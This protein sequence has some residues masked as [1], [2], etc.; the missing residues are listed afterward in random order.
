MR[1]NRIFGAF[2]FVC[3]FAS[4][5]FSQLAEFKYKNLLDN[6]SETGWYSIELGD[7]IIDKYHNLERDIRIFETGRDTIEIP[8][9]LRIISDEVREENVKID[10]VNRSVKDG[11][12]YF[13]IIPQGILN[14]LNLEIDQE[15]F[16]CQVD[17]EGSNDQ[18]EWFQIT[19]N[20]RIV[21]IKANNTRFNYSEVEFPDADFK[22]LRI[23]IK[24]KSKID[25][26]RVYAKRIRTKPGSYKTCTIDTFVVR[27]DEKN[28]KS[29]Y[30]I[31]F[32]SR[33]PV[34]EIEVIMD[35]NRDFFRNVNIYYVFDSIKTEHGTYPSYSLASNVILASFKKNQYRL[36]PEI[37]HGLR[38]EI[39]N[40]DNPP[41][42]IKEVNISG[43]VY[44]L[45]A[46]LEKGKKYHLVCDNDNTSYPT[47]EIHDLE[48]L[49]PDQPLKIGYGR[50]MKMD[51][52][53]LEKG[54]SFIIGKIWLWIVIIVAVAILGFFSFRMMKES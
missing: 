35:S 40:Y 48:Q 54:S 9:L 50:I 10:I 51:E 26:N 29:I 47:Y 38:L 28:K 43:P 36:S 42:T 25:L 53:S 12:Y 2:I 14:H 18:S 46:Q 24:S 45:I 34:S 7:D 15:N 1:I 49:I 11:D 8:Y 30:D 31:R 17:I 5:V 19:K 4:A 6:V 33:F 21:G 44:E 23:Q 39:L 3:V 41:I 22:Y 27:E 16:N 20:Q 13:T 52:E 32:K 37:I